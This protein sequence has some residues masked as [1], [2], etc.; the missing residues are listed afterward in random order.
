MKSFFLIATFSVVCII[1]IFTGIAS[2]TTGEPP[3]ETL[4]ESKCATYLYSETLFKASVNQKQMVSPAKINGQPFNFIVEN[5]DNVDTM[6]HKLGGAGIND[7]VNIGEICDGAMIKA[8]FK[9]L[10]VWVD[11]TALIN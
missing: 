4:S 1:A 2:C 3:V 10:R 6:I 9:K 11:S 7:F 8:R 5:G